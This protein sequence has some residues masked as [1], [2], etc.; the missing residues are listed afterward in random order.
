[1]YSILQLL[2]MA[3]G[4]VVGLIMFF[5][6]IVIGVVAIVRRRINVYAKRRAD[7]NASLW[8]GIVLVLGGLL[9]PI[10]FGLT[11]L[12]SL[13]IAIVIGFLNLEDS[14]LAHPVRL[15]PRTL[16]E[17]PLD[18]GRTGSANSGGYSRTQTNS[19]QY[20]VDEPDEQFPEPEAL[21]DEAP[22]KL[23]EL[24]ENAFAPGMAY[25]TPAP[26]QTLAQ[27]GPVLPSKIA[28]REP[29]PEAYLENMATLEVLKTELALPN[30]INVDKKDFVIGRA[31][32]SDLQLLDEF[33]SR[34][35][36]MLRYAQG[37]WFIQDPGSRSGIL[38]NDQP[39]KATRLQDGDYITIGTNIFIFRIEYST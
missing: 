2:Q 17:F 38:V 26:P 25:S 16:T 20:P 13:G 23:E 39:V 6:H 8:I 15:A 11:G 34:R 5:G 9:A 10:T 14:R 35:H 37:M 30:L 33:V 22:D 18:Y 1:M 7:Q 27:A 29:Q 28:S 4:G 32:D 31:K 12:L 36:A 24:P 3:F 19:D 21:D